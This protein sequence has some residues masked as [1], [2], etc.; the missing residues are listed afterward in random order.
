MA[1][2]VDL[3]ADLTLH[4]LHR[5]LAALNRRLARLVREVR[6]GLDAAVREDLLG[7]YIT[8][9]EVDTLLSELPAPQP[10]PG[11]RPGDAGGHR[12][13]LLAERLGLDAFARDVVL[14]GMAPEVDVR[15]ERVFVYLHNDITRRRPSVG[16]ALRLLDRPVERLAAREAFAAAAPLRRHHVVALGA[17]ESGRL[18]PPL[19][20]LALRLDDRIA[21]F[22]LGS[23]ACDDRLGGAV[24]VHT[25]GAFAEPPAGL[26]DRLDRLA[27]LAERGRARIACLHGPDPGA[28]RDAAVTVAARTARQLVEI[29]AAALSV[30]GDPASGR[31]RAERACREVRLRPHA[32]AFVAG[33]DALRGGRRAA[34]GAPRRC[35]AGGHADHAG[36]GPAGAR[37]GQ[38]GPHDRDPRSRVRGAHLRVARGAAGNG[39]GRGPRR[40]LPVDARADRRRRARGP[41]RGRPARGRRAQRGR[42][43]P[44]R[45]R[46]DQRGARPASAADAHAARL[47]GPG[48]AAGPARAPARRRRAPTAPPHGLR[49]VGLRRPAGIWDGDH[50]A[51]RR[52]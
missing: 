50:G 41:G 14:L 26:L 46:P 17:D 51:V 19:P 31:E 42:P 45:A 6:P 49:A 48:A 47:R 25:P 28:L 52:A 3:V 44:G 38:R 24:A 18:A 10:G 30:E 35:G 37:G 7:L 20:A 5:G 33:F 1:G 8:D 22:L 12:L 21:A 36:I 11:E 43:G 2:A 34:R 15:Y 40:P 16:L 23:D 13:A 4:E 9:A 27:S 39:P 32:L 29:D